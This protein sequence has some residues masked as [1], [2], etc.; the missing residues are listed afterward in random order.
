MWKKES[1]SKNALY[2]NICASGTSNDEIHKDVRAEINEHKKMTALY[3]KSDATAVNKRKYAHIAFKKCEMHDAID[4]LNESLCFAEKKSPN[5]GIAYADRST[6]FFNLKMY[7]KCLVDIDLALK[8]NCPRHL[9]P[10][11]EQLKADCYKC[12]ADGAQ[13]KENHLSLDF[14]EKEGYPGWSEAFDIQKGSN[15]QISVVATQNIG[16]GQI[17]AIDKAFTKTLFMIYGWRCNI[18]LRRLTNLVPCKKCTT[19]MFCVECVDNNLHRYECGMKT[20][21][22]SQYNNNLMLEL[23]TFFVAMNLFATADEMMDFVEKCL[24]AECN[25]LPHPFDEPRSRY[26]AFLLLHNQPAVA[27]EEFGQIVNCTYR[28]LLD[29]PKV[30]WDNQFDDSNEQKIRFL[31]N[32]NA[33]FLIGQRNV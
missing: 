25:E 29:I 2:I 1:N 21:L 14:P 7:D 24:A 8:F 28:I 20:S 32:L 3:S 10:A 22:W 15:G 16:I 4:L 17:V 18:C 9:R 11:L 13:L 31:T 26:R 5:M 6:C 12:I 33:F 30:S 19:A 23:R 27:H